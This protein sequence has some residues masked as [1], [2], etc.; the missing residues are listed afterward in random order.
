MDWKAALKAVVP[1]LGAALPL[2][3]PIGS[4]ATKMVVDA[5]LGEKAGDEKTNSKLMGALLSNP[6]PE[7]LLK[8]KEV[9]T[10]FDI[11]MKELGVDMERVLLE[12][13]KTDAANTDS[14]RTMH[15][16]TK[17]RAPSIIS[18]VVV[19]GFFLTVSY[20][21]KYGVPQNDT[22]GIV[23]LLIGTLTSGFATVLNFWLGS[24]RSSQDKTALLKQ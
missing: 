14:A 2:P 22:S 6:T 7:I 1:A 17:S 10:S 12:Q 19:F 4:L 9:E 23:F 13:A 11:R 24:S 5:V 15:T 3:P 20:L 16:A 8:I 18:A 21:L